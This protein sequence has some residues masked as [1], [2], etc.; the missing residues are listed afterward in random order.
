MAPLARR[1]GQRLPL[2]EAMQTKLSIDALLEELRDQV[3]VCAQSRASLVGHSWGAWLCL[4]FAA[5]YSDMAK[6]LILVSSGV[7]EERYVEFL[8]VNQTAR[9]TD[10]EQA[11]DGQASALAR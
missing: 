8:K 11:E 7:L 6:Q 3:A 5:R 1:L 4:L 10:D 2:V 9:L